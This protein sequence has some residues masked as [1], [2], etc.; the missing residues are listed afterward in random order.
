MVVVHGEQSEMPLDGI[1]VTEE[2]GQVFVRGQ[3]NSVRPQIDVT[4]IVALLDETGYGQWEHD[5]AGIAQAAE[6]CNTRETPFV[7]LVA[8]RRDAR[9]RDPPGVRP[10]RARGEHDPGVDHLHVLLSA[11]QR[12]DLRPTREGRHGQDERQGAKESHQ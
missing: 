12:R 5:S 9:I 1:A 8:E 7:V 10:G 11:T 3:P 2:S 4:S 6:D